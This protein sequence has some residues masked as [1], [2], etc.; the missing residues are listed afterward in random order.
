MKLQ[1]YLIDIEDLALYH[2]NKANTTRDSQWLFGFM[3]HTK[4]VFT[5]HFKSIKCEIA[6]CLKLYINTL[7]KHCFILFF[8]NC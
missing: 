2:Y 8:K 4:V 1:V 6:L 3:V 5:Q 7:I